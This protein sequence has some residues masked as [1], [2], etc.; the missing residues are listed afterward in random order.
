[1]KMDAHAEIFGTLGDDTCK[2]DDVIHGVERFVCSL[3]GIPK[4]DSV[5]DARFAIFQH[6]YALHERDEPLDKIKGIKPAICL[7]VEMF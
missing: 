4:L 7:H 5:N 2:I 3:Y 1:M 6:R